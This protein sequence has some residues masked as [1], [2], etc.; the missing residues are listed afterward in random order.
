MTRARALKQQIRH[1]A[2]RTGE[3]YTT[4][5]RHVLE[6]LDAR[7][8]RVKSTAPVK[9]DVASASKSGISDKRFAEK[10]GQGLDHWFAV[11][12]RFGAVEKGHT[13]AARHLYEAYGV[14]GWWAQGITV[15]YERARGVRAVNQRCDGSYEVSVSKVLAADT[16]TVVRWLKDPRRR[17]QLEG[18]DE[19]LVGA[20]GAAIDSSPSKGFVVRAD[21]RGRLRYKWNDT[22]V[23]VMILPKNGGRVS[24]VVTNT[25]LANASMVAERRALWRAMLGALATQLS[26]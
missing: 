20:L 9:A 21:G 25:K 11:L 6:H 26:A 7:H 3:R 8:R 10:T 23:E 14:G 12:D 22:T 1:R 24:L 19:E 4:A 16:A 5:R 17:R 15:A 2:A 18:V 13:A